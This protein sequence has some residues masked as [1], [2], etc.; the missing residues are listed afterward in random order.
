MSETTCTTCNG[1]GN[2]PKPQAETWFHYKDQLGR[3]MG[4]DLT[5]V[6]G[7][8]EEPYGTPQ[9]LIRGYFQG[10][11]LTIREYWFPRDRVEEVLHLAGV[12]CKDCKGWG[13][14]HAC[15]YCESP[16][17]DSKLCDDCGAQQYAFDSAMEMKG[18]Y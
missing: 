9:L 16:A 1:T 15:E 17:P 13:K 3:S 18:E 4:V 14:V 10:Q 6:L 7:I 5:R 12:T 11:P 2:P 8:E